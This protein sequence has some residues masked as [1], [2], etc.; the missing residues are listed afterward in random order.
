MPEER[1]LEGKTLLLVDGSSY[2]YRAYHAMPDLRGPGGEPTGALYGIINMLRRM[3]KEVSAEY[4]AC[5]FDAKGKT[6]RDDLYADYKA[7]RPSMPPDL[8][9]Q[10]EPI[11]GAVRALG[12]P[13]LM[14][15][16]VEADDVIGTLAR[17][18][19]RHGMN[20]IVS[21][22][23]KDLAQ[24]VT[25]HVTLVN[26]MTNETLDRDGV[27][28]K[29][30]V[31]PERIID[32]LALIG[33]T[34]DNVPGVE[35]CGPKTAVKWLSQYDS[36]DGVIEH[37]GEIKGV[38]GDNLR[39]ALDFLP[40]GRKLVTVDTACDLAPHLESIEASLKSDGEARDLLRDIFARY[41]FK[42]WLRE[43]DSAPAEGGGADAPEGDPAPV[44]AADIVREYDTIQTW[45]QFDAWF[46]K[47]DAAAL[48]AFDTE[49]T[50]LDP[51]TARLVGLSFSVE[52]G[53]AA[54]L[55]VAHRGP[56]MPEQ[57]PIDDVLARLKPWLESADRKKVGQ[58]LKYDAQV[59]AN[60]DIALNGI[61]HDTLLESYVLESH[62]THDMDSLALRHLGVKTIKYEDVAGKGAKQIGFDEVA[63][64]QAAAYA[65][66]D[67]DITLQL[68]Q[69]LYPQVAREAGLERVYREIEMPVSLVL[70]KM[71]RTGVLIDDARLQA[72]SSEIATRLIELE[73]QAYELAGGE[74]N[75]GSPKQIGQIFFEKLQLPVVKKTPSGAPSTDE[76]VLQ[77]LAEDYPLPKLLLEHRGLSKLKSTYTD[78]LPRMVNPATG[79]VHTNYAQAVA[80]TGRLASN[81]PNLQN[82]PVRTAEGRRIREA[83]I[84]SPGHRIVSADYSQIELRI[85]AH[86]SGDAS[87]LRA[88]SQG[89]DIHRA[90]AAEVFGVTPLEVNSDQRRIAKVINFGLIYGMSAFGLASNL[91]I[92]RDAAKLY[93]DRYFARYPGVAQYMENTRAVA[94]E[95]GYVETVF[96]RRLWLP[97][98]NGGNGPRRQA[99]ERAAINAPMQG[100]AADLIKLSMIAVDDW[101]TRDRLA[102]RMIMQVHDELVLE[103]PDAELSLVREKLP[104]M[105]CGVAKLKVPLVAEV[106]A[107]ANWEEAH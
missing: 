65:A 9:L 68:H 66:E 23:D 63:L 16:G 12:W 13:L 79:R 84:A 26:T 5:V 6:F 86:I 89:E 4:S 90:T 14:V 39:R 41:G 73:G 1:N 7:N 104:E 106:G 101:L 38:V 56:D 49:T 58:H 78:K 34:V 32:Y 42:T 98:I 3:R 21:T 8:A 87:L 100:T 72:Q 11:H 45:E 24:L 82:I 36:L 93:I 69:A 94:K 50:S 31:P 75:L 44:V 47:I 46:A 27:V 55:P 48:T 20:V 92:T 28:A 91:G 97:E 15:E 53:K 61:E 35:K 103:V 83:F 17:E 70:R 18:A 60:Y 2:L 67:A 80:V 25:D 81:D 77:K 33:D 59:L 102:S 40:L 19:E 62:R 95:K 29:F 54:Y 22:G 74:F 85:M 51:M 64:E 96:G 71:E 57:L 52:P 88:F 76:E 99:A 30:G 43:V 10:V 107:G 37:A 105:M